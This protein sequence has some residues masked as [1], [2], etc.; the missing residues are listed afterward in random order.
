MLTYWLLR[1]LRTLLGVL[2]TN[3]SSRQV[4]AG[5]AIGVVLGAAPL[6]SLTA[7]ALGVVLCSLRVNKAAGL[8]AAAGVAAATPLLDP[9]TH[10]LGLK[11]LTVPS[12]QSTYAAAYDAPLGPW[13]GLHNTVACGSLL[14]GLYLSYPVF[15]GTR[16]L[17]DRARPWAVKHI[18]K[19]K[20]GRVL[21]GAQITDRLGASFGIGS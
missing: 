2:L 9:F 20:L 11:V 7:V 8:L 16:A 5:V 13:W 21:L 1:P 15:L 12:L 19:Y 6:G 17:V 10:K 4:A 18:A 3:D 14:L